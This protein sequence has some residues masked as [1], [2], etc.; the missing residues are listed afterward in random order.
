MDERIS[1]NMPAMQIVDMKEEVIA[2]NIGIFSAALMQAL[3]QTVERGEQAMIFLNRRGHS[4][5]VMCKKCG[6]IA[7]CTDCD[8]TL[9]YHSVDNLL[10][11]HYCGKRYKML[12]CCH[13][14]GSRDIRYG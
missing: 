6:Y 7:K 2:G 14:C 12:E 11:C 8:I 10:K 5:F 3:R 1:G 4:S 13:E 9:T